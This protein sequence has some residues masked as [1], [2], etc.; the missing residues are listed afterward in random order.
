MSSMV[1]DLYD[2]G[3]TDSLGGMPNFLEDNDEK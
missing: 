3:L 1:Q 2:M